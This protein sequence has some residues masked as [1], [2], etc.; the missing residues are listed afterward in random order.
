MYSSLKRFGEFLFFLLYIDKIRLSVIR[1]DTLEMD[2][3]ITKSLIYFVGLA[4][5]FATVKAVL[6][7]IRVEKSKKLLHNGVHC[8]NQSKGMINKV[9]MIHRIIFLTW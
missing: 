1:M 5:R 8:Q 7:Y 9:N 3:K 4:D 6:L 2:K